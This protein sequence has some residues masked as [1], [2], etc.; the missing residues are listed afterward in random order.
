[1]DKKNKPVYHTPKVLPLSNLM[2]S[3]G[4]QCQSGS[5]ESKHCISGSIA[6]GKGG[7]CST[8]G[9]ITAAAVRK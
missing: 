1:M 2:Q 7:T 8:G 3:T 4:A 5:G 6:S 9:G